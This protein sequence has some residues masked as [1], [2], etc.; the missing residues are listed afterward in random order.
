MRRV[1][2]SY[3]LTHLQLWSECWLISSHRCVV[4]V[5]VF[6][7]SGIFLS[8]YFIINEQVRTQKKERKRNE[9]NISEEN[10]LC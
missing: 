6:K 4:Y 9:K 1:I 10:D 5:C 3:K 8:P 7:K 2:A